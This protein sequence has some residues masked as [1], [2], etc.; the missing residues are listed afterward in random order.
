M[1]LGKR[2][3]K[4]FSWAVFSYFGYKI[5]RYVTG[6]VNITKEL[7][8]YLKNVIGET[9]SMNITVVFNRLRV[10]LLFKKETIDKNPDI[11]DT[12]KEYILR[13]Y[14]I[15][16]QDHVEISVIQKYQKDT[17]EKVEETPEIVPEKLEPEKEEKTED[18]PE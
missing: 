7:P 3:M 17:E 14:P 5:Y 16:R 12:A 9:P 1:A 15:F 13:Y 4:L 2:C 8:V 6:I 11:A 10:N 18:K